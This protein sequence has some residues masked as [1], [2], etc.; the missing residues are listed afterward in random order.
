MLLLEKVTKS[1]F[2]SRGAANPVSNKCFQVMSLGSVFVG[3][4]DYKIEA[5]NNHQKKKKWCCDIR[6]LSILRLIH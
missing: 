5:N 6:T 1:L 2:V 4:D 3:S